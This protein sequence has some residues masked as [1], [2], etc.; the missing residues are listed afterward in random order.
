MNVSRNFLVLASLFLIVGITIGSYMGG[1]GDHTLAVSH[2]HINLLG[3]TLSAIFALTYK[4]F[5]AMA[6]SRL[7]SLH[8]WLHAVGAVV[9]NTMLFLML[10]GMVAEAAMFPIAPITELLVLLGVILF[11]SNVFSN[12]H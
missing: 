5:P 11:A 9:L 8:F 1:S 3:F 10:A 4:A 6:D 12:A 2:A 7:A